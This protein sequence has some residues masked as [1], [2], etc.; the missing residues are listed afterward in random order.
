MAATSTPRRDSMFIGAFRSGG[1]D[2]RLEF[3]AA[4]LHCAQ[5]SEC[6]P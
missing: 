4:H 2:F 5:P 3:S 6:K 1:M